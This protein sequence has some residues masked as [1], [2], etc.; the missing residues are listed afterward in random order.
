MGHWSRFRAILRLTP[1][2]DGTVS[3]TIM[4][5]HYVLGYVY[6]YLKKSNKVTYSVYL[7]N[8]S[9]ECVSIEIQIQPNPI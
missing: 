5:T 2:I 8:Y 9:N 4:H 6:L 7:M 1:D 3:I